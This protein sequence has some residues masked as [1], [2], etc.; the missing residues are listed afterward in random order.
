MA[1]SFRN[2]SRGEMNADP[3]EGE[4]FTPEGLAD[5]LV[6]ESIQ[7]SLDAR[8]PREAGAPVQVCLRFS[9]QLGALTP[10]RGK[11]YLAGLWPHLQSIEDGRTNLPT[12]GEPCH[13]S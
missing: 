2:M 5:S 3:I 7:N 12:L 13:I 1:W 10:V 8:D 4:F 6:R 11:A 9:G